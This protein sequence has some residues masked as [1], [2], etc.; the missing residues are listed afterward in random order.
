MCQQ[1]LAFQRIFAKP[2]S[3]N[4]ELNNVLGDNR[5]SFGF[6]VETIKEG[7]TRLVVPKLESFRKAPWEYAPSKAPVF[8][9]PAMKLNRDIATL[10][11]QAYQRAIKRDVYVSEPLAGC[12]VRGIRFAKEVDGIRAVHMNDINPEAFKMAQ[13]NIQLND[14]ADR[15]SIANEDA[16]LFLSQYAAPYKRFDYI[17]IDP[18]GTPVLY[19]DSAIRSLR[20]GGMLALT[21]TDLAPLCGVFPKAALRKYGGLPLRTEYCHEIAMRLMLGNLATSAARY[22]MGTKIV[23]SHSS[24]HYVRAYAL[25]SYGAKKANH[26]ISNMGYIL[27]CFSCFHRETV[28]SFT[29]TVQKVC[30]VCGS[31]LKYAGPLWLGNIADSGM[32]ELME[33]EVD[34]GTSRHWIGLSKML[35]LVKQ[36]VNAPATFYVV[37]KICDKINIPVPPLKK[38]IVYLKER[39]FVAIPTHFHTRGLK[40]TAPAKVV[41]EAVERSV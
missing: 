25:L 30:S 39:N 37:D 24:D 35:S 28:T 21:A 3:N 33:K 34:D 41:I 29:P 12:G 10:V 9:N 27:H 7:A 19:V 23:F 13:H 22:E 8:Y 31:P 26:S 14:V 16:N 6:P 40:T 15:V 5:M 36:E 38:V 32:C 1:F 20:N 11:L 17:D 2:F 18:F 4:K